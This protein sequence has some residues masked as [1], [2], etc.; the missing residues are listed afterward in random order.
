MSHKVPEDARL[1]HFDVRYFLDLANARGFYAYVC[2][3]VDGRGN[4]RNGFQLF[5][6]L[7]VMSRDEVM[8]LVGMN[9]P[10]N[11]EYLYGRR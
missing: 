7:S 8:R 10:R 5:R 4:E 3:R 2:R 6:E 9:A 11:I 1:C